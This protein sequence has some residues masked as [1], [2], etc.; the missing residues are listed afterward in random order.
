[1][2]TQTTELEFC[3]DKYTDIPKE[4]IVKE[5]IL[6]RGVNFTDAALTVQSGFQR[7]AYF[8]FTFDV[9]VPADV[10][11]KA[12]IIPQEIRI[13]GGQFGLRPTIVQC[14]QS[15][16]SIYRVDLVDGRL[17]LLCGDLPLAG[18]EFAPKHAYY[19]FRLKDGTSVET[20]APAI[21]WGQTVDVTAFRTCQYWGEKEECKFC[22]INENYREWGS[23]RKQL[24]AIVPVEKVAEAVELSSRDPNAKRYLITGGAIKDP[25]KEVEF[26]LKYIKVTEERLSRDFPCRLNTQA[27]VKADCE[28]FYEAG[29]DYYHPNLEVWDPKL[30]SVI[31]P[32][33]DKFIG[34]EEWINRTIEASRVFGVGNVSPNF[35]AGVEMA[36]CNGFEIGFKNSKDAVRSTLEGIEFFMSEEVTPKFDNWAVE[37]L[38]WFGKNGSRGPPLEYFIDLYAGYYDL[39]K[40]YG[41]PWPQGLGEAGP[42]RCMVPATAFMDIGN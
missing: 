14:R 8:L 23:L 26:Y 22:D 2:A 7:K 25:K 24:G 34:R 10:K 39:K 1:M 36:E 16:S 31:C 19:D 38:S 29:V 4:L 13:E 21:Y 35:V 41:L 27:F 20:I 37:P 3:F 33:K 11:S 30:F 6:S 9:D 32:G 28:K 42:G 12:G 5:D 40:R 17:E 18:V 15:S